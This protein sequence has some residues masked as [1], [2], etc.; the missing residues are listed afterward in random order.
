MTQ[1]E[2]ALGVSA[3]SRTFGSRRAVDNVSFSLSRGETL[4]V[5]GPNGAGK[6]TLLRL[7]S[8][9]LRPEAGEISVGG[10][11]FRGQAELRGTVGLISHRSMLYDALTPRENVEFAARLYGL[12]NPEVAAGTV[13]SGMG[14]TRDDVPVR[15]L[16]RGM[17]QRV[18]IARA[19]VHSPALV[20][21]DEP[22]TGLD[23]GGAGALT[24]LLRELSAK[25]AAMV[26]VTHNLHE[27][28]ALATRAAVMVKGAFAVTRECRATSVDSFGD[29][30]RALVQADA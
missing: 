10:V 29:E 24:D 1:P 9:L 27:G 20:L 14:V 15:L 26:V 16:S 12:K 2:P 17:Q 25:G 4:A 28:L 13:L 23:E 19:V 30:Y 11:S 22:Y 18:S 5:F 21:A 3:L 7:L 8:G 6:T